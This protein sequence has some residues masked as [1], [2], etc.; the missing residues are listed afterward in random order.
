MPGGKV[1]HRPVLAPGQPVLQR[2]VRPVVGPGGKTIIR[3]AVPSTVS[4]L[5]AKQA[6]VTPQAREKRKFDTST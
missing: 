2:G 3:P 4:A 5:A 1:V 6:S